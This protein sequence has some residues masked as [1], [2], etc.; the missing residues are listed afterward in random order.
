MMKSLRFL[1]MANGVFSAVAGRK[2][3]AMKGNTAKRSMIADNCSA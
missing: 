2:S 1:L 3:A